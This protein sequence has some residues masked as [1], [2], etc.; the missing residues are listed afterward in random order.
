[1]G[2]GGLIVWGERRGGVTGDVPFHCIRR[3]ASLLAVR[4][5]LV[6]TP[7][8]AVTFVSAPVLPCA[9]AEVV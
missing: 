6:P 7:T 1:M 2:G 4:C 5:R 9:K 8:A 3:N